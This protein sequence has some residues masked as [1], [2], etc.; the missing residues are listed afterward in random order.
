MKLDLERE[1]VHVDTLI[2]KEEDFQARCND[3]IA[4]ADQEEDRMLDAYKVYGILQ[5][6]HDEWRFKVPT[7]TT[8]SL[9]LCSLLSSQRIR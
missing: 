9:P 7:T 4:L 2:M 6:S 3:E 5:V 1:R 8:P